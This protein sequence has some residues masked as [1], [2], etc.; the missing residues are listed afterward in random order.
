MTY[1]DDLQQVIAGLSFYGCVNLANI[2]TIY[3][4]VPANRSQINEVM[5]GLFNRD[6]R[7]CGACRNGYSPLVY[8]YQ[9]HCKNCTNADSKYNWAKFVAVAFIPLTGFYIFVVMFKF[10]SNSPKLHCLVLFAH[11]TTNPANIRIASSGWRFGSTATFLTKM[12]VTLYGI[13]NLD[14]FCTLYPDICLRLTT[15]QALSLDY[16]IAFYPLALIVITCVAVR[17][18]YRKCMW[19]PIGRYYTFWFKDKDSSKT[20]MIDVFATFLLLSYSK[21]LSVN[22]DLLAFTTPVNS[23]SKSVGRFLYYDASYKWFGQH[24][25]PYGVFCHPIICH[26]QSFT[27][28][29]IVVLSHEVLSK[30]IK[31]FEAESPYVAHIR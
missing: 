1:D 23:S 22:F 8:S 12:F 30:D 21:I 2:D 15:L 10:N 27:T 24:H 7:L 16:V 6:G 29:I 13:W 17:A 26:H 28:A 19:K 31:Q 3:H 9:L 25:L 20:S 11:L 18:N 5:C 4:H 14:F